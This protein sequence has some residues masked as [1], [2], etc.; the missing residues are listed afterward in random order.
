MQAVNGVAH[1]TNS[2]KA[3]TQR[4]KCEPLASVAYY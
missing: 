2:Y 3:L 4:N 1:I